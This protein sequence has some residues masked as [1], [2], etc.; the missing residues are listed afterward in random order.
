MTDFQVIDLANQ[1]QQVAQYV[2]GWSKDNILTWLGRFGQVKILRSDDSVY[3]FNSNSGIT[4]GFVLRDNGDF[5]IVGDHTTR[6][7]KAE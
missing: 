4:T 7:V 5:L 6:Q 3:A 1:A 2:K